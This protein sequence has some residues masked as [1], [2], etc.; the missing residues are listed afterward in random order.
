[1]RDQNQPQGITDAKYSDSYLLMFF[2]SGILSFVVLGAGPAV[3]SSISGWIMDHMG[4]T[5]TFCIL[6]AMITI[7]LIF[8]IIV[9]MIL[10]K[11]DTPECQQLL[12]SDEK[13]SK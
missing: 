8:S 3:G 10:K 11:T 9:Q 5:A 13:I 1:M 2:L 7:I 12:A 6:A 4:Q